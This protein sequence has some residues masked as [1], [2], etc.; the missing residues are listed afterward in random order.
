MTLYALRSSAAVASHHLAGS[1]S[2]FPVAFLA[3]HITVAHI[4]RE[5]C[6]FVVEI[7]KFP[8]GRHVTRGA[9]LA[10]NAGSELVAMRVL[11]R[12]TSGALLGGAGKL[13]CGSGVAIN[14]LDFDV[15]S[16][17]SESG[18][19]VI[20]GPHGFPLFRHMTRLALERRLVRIGM[21]SVARLGGEM[22]LA[23]R[24]GKKCFGQRQRRPHGSQK[25]NGQGL[26]RRLDQLVAIGAHEKRVAAREV[27][28]GIGMPHDRKRGRREAVLGMAAIAFV[29]VGG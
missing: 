22:K 4:Q 17:E 18:A 27:E 5:S 29:L 21:T 20:E 28:P 26:G 11:G 23:E 3:G 16:L 2:L 6:P 25:R 19:G 10:L 9:V 15:A 1:P 7:L 12:M 13:G 8:L 24:A 14:A